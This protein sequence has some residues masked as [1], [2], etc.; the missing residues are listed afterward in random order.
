MRV[1]GQLLTEAEPERTNWP[2]KLVL[3]AGAGSTG[4]GTIA[5]ASI[6]G[7]ATLAIDND[8]AA[9]R[10]ALREGEVDFVVNTLDEALRVLKNQLRLRRPLGV[11]LTAQPEPAL[12]EARE[13]G[14]QPDFVFVTEPPPPTEDLQNLPG[15]RL[16]LEGP[17]ASAGFAR[18]LALRNWRP[19][20]VKAKDAAALRHVDTRL[21][22]RIGESGPRSAWVRGIVR[23]QRSADA[24][25]RVV[26]LSEEERAALERE[27]IVERICSE[28]QFA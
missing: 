16:M 24:M 22:A 7:A 13:R 25:V 23:Y 9:V 15:R 28:D 12:A 2:G 19:F 1:Y 17:E 26:W 20:V 10:A 18:W 27:E 4:K 5:A 11:A 21:Q 8:R 6:A 14:L 3:M